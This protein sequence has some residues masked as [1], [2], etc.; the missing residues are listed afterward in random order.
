VRRRV[1]PQINLV[2]G[3]PDYPAVLDIHAPDRVLSRGSLGFA[4]NGKRSLHPINTGIFRS[5]HCLNSVAAAWEGR[6]QSG[7]T[8]LPF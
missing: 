5:R 1:V 2:A 3:L 6:F 4:S 7:G 8:D